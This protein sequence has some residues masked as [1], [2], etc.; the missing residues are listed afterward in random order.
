MSRPPEEI[1]RSAMDA[2]ERG[3]IPAVL[4]HYHPDCTFTDMSEG[5]SRSHGELRPYLEDYYAHLP[6][7]T[8]RV[9]SLVVDGNRLAGEIEVEGRYTG[10]GAAPGGTPI[11]LHY[12]VLDE[13]ED[14]MI[15]T[16]K[17]YSD[18]AEFANQLGN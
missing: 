15:K 11:T 16:E 10:D 14:G 4:A 9:V 18:S 2:V 3:D 6:I 17:V 5:A 13:Y 8:L 1:F 12:V 7:D